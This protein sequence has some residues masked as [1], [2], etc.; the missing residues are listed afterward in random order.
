MSFIS[1]I[2]SC[3]HFRKKSQIYQ[4]LNSYM[5]TKCL[6]FTLF[7]SLSNSLILVLSMTSYTYLPISLLILVTINELQIV[8]YFVVKFSSRFLLLFVWYK[9]S[10]K[11]EKKLMT[12]SYY[13]TADLTKTCC[14]KVISNIS[15]FAYVMS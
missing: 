13:K 9:F 1:L 4:Y 6:P 2:L 14:N 11:K 15:Q 7:L 12:D 8:T 5:H 3:S 10:L